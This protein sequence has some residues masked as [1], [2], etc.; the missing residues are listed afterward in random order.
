MTMRRLISAIVLSSISGASPSFAQSQSEAL[1][2]A[3]T[4][5]NAGD[6]AGG[7]EVAQVLE[8]P[9]ALDLLAWTRLRRGEGSF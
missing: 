4:A 8:D 6:L 9:V 5:Y 3:L 1:A 2:A 7:S